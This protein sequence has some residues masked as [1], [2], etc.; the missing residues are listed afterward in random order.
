MENGWRQS[1]RRQMRKLLCDHAFAWPCICVTSA[2]VPE[3]SG[4]SYGANA[5][6]DIPRLHEKNHS[7]QA[8]ESAMWKQLNIA[9]FKPWS[10]A[11][12]LFI[13]PQSS[14]LSTSMITLLTAAFI[15]GYF[16]R[17]LPAK[18]HELC[19]PTAERRCQWMSFVVVLGGERRLHQW[20]NFREN[21]VSK[22]KLL[23]WC[24]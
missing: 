24:I 11:V 5:W 23:L 22:T 19:L 6:W 17:D 16:R 7:F 8:R 18:S 3:V 15:R 4:A 21:V 14:L 1:S 9:L 20:M 12:F 13:L 10:F 2:G